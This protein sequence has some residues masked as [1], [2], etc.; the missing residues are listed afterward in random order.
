MQSPWLLCSAPLFLPSLPTSVQW[1]NYPPRC[2][3][4]NKGGIIN[5]LPSSLLISGVTVGAVTFLCSALASEPGRHHPSVN[6]CT[7]PVLPTNRS[8]SSSR[9]DYVTLLLKTLFIASHAIWNVFKFL[10][11][12][13]NVLCHLPPAFLT[14]LIT[15]ASLLT[16]CLPA[17]QP[18]A[19]SLPS[20]S[21]L[22]RS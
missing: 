19:F 10:P 11:V 9:T 14:D 5:S 15:H 6:S 22:Q 2:P 8:P 17:P 20:L 13:L 21:P 18:S 3:S 4:Q 1:H 16:R 7:S 12:V